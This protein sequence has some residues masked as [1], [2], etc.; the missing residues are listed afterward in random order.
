ML[1][2]IHTHWR[3]A[4]LSVAA[5][6]ALAG[7][8]CQRGREGETPTTESYLPL[9]ITRPGFDVTPIG[10]GFDYVTVVTHAGN[11][12]LFV[13]ERAGR[14]KIIHPDGAITP[15][16][17]IA[18]R[19]YIAGGEYGFFDIAFHPQYADPDA[20]GRGFFYVAY[21]TSPNADA[22]LPEGQPPDVD[23]I[24]SRFRVSADPDAA[25]PD[26][27]TVLLREPQFSEV[28]KGGALAFDPRDNRLYAGVGEDFQAMLAQ[29]SDSPKGKIIRIDVDAVPGDL[30]GDAT[31]HVGL[32]IAAYG[33]RNPWRIDLDVESNR[34]YIGDVGTEHWEEINVLDLDGEAV[35]YGWPCLE[36]PYLFPHLEQEPRCQTDF[37]PPVYQYSREDNPGSCAVIGGYVYRPAADPDDGRF[38]FSDLCTAEIL[39][40][41][42]QGGEWKVATLGRHTGGIFSSFGEG[43]DGELYLGSFGSDVP[44]YRL[45]IP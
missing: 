45:E 35:N 2:R 34:L 5:L 9:A 37:T 16:L 25:D 29:L 32:D 23:L 31:A 12:R 44:I 7:A 27:E 11:A 20:P 26:S 4:A 17:D 10:E 38:I 8:G 14:I 42:Q 19:V 3:A 24:I 21:T 22:Q 28:H 15:F 30:R 1:N 41:S 13:G 18:E 39:T 43:P 6:I 33:L 36:G 40:L